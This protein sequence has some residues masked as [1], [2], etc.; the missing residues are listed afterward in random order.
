MGTSLD[1][2]VK[3]VFL[4]SGNVPGSF[5]QVPEDYKRYDNHIRKKMKYLKLVQRNVG[6]E[7][8]TSDTL[9][10]S[11]F[12]F[13]DGEERGGGAYMPQGLYCLLNRM[14]GVPQERKGFHF[15]ITW[16]A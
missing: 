4:K 2:D 8:L 6:T 15:F 3:Q 12:V 10:K 14:G 9:V 11:S 13:V 1:G 16:C 7:E 5:S